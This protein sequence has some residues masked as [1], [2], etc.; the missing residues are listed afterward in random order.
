MNVSAVGGGSS[1]A[2]VNSTAIKA[3]VDTGG[4]NNVK[5]QDFGVRILRNGKQLEEA[6]LQGVKLSIGEEQIIKAIDRA[7]RAVEG[8]ATKLEM[9]VHKETKAVMVKVLN[10]ET[11]ELI[12]EIPPEKTLDF[13][14]KMME[15]AGIIVDKKI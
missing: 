8:N 10:K 6:E 15:F 13:V 4:Q 14:V 11:G 9:E 5:P 1:A 3:A 12:R 2:T 7:I